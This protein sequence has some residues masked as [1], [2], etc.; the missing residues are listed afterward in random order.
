MA[1]MAKTAS[2]KT[3][4]RIPNKTQWALSDIADEC[5]ESRLQWDR[6]MKMAEQ[7]V[8]PQMAM[9]LARL[10][11]HIANIERIAVDAKSGEYNERRGE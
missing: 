10:R 11:D 1:K 5:L 4:E 8:D 2:A 6:L 9:Y 7:R 3:A